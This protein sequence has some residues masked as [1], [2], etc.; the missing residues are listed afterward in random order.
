MTAPT[1]LLAQEAKR[2][3]KLSRIGLSS[4]RRRRLLKIRRSRQ[5]RRRPT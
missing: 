2:E 5:E 4:A 3:G 1:A